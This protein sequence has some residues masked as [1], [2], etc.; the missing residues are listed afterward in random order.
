M[1]SD[2]APQSPIA[3]RSERGNGRKI[4]YAKGESVKESSER[5]KPPKRGK[6]AAA[7]AEKGI[8][9]VEGSGELLK[10][11]ESSERLK[12][13]KR[14]KCADAEKGIENVEGSGELLKQPKGG[15]YAAADVDEGIQRDKKH[16]LHWREKSVYSSSLITSSAGY[17]LKLHMRERS[18]YS[19][20]LITSKAG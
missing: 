20:S 16:C 13:P 4:G 10:Q 17:K 18:V 5:L 19:S 3:S 14:G 8:E 7:D 2:H 11:Q 9:N 6:C 1:R 12:P 15:S